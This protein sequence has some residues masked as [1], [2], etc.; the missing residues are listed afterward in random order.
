M[1]TTFFDL[2]LELRD[3]IWRKTRF[4]VALS[5][6]TRKLKIQT[7]K[8]ITNRVRKIDVIFVEFQIT[9]TKTMS[10]ENV[11]YEHEINT[12]IV[13]IKDPAYIKVLLI[14]LYFSK[15]YNK[16][17]FNYRKLNINSGVHTLYKDNELFKCN[18][19]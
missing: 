3:K 1:T 8:I 6:I 4:L 5:N 2:P 14:R 19:T 7:Q 16:R 11:L 17:S 13:G 15:D 12:L 9:S 10:I 18:W